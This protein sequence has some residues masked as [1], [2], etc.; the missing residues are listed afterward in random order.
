LPAEQIHPRDKLSIPPD[1]LDSLRNDANGLSD[2]EERNKTLELIHKLEKGVR[3]HERGMQEIQRK[4]AAPTPRVSRPKL[5]GFILIFGCFAWFF[6]GGLISI[7]DDGGY[8]ERHTGRFVTEA[9]DAIAYWWGIGFFSFSSSLSL[10][11]TVACIAALLTYP[12]PLLDWLRGR[13]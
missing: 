2:S 3:Y 11:L 4:F 8:T 5:F 1:V 7:L 6:T 13:K 12:V 10:V 9:T